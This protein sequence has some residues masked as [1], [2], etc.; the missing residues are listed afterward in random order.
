MWWGRAT[1]MS[2]RPPNPGRCPG[3]RKPGPSA[4]PPAGIS[5]NSSPLACPNTWCR[6][7]TS[8]WNPCH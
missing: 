2:S 4:L 1:G 5:D 7:R 6:R 3:L 8:S